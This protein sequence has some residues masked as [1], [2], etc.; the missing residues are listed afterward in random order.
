M[1]RWAKVMEIEF[2]N[3]IWINEQM[4]VYVKDRDPSGSI[5]QFSFFDDSSDNYINVLESFEDIVQKWDEW[6]SLHKDA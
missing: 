6:Q 1:N 2:G 3:D 4:V 5:I